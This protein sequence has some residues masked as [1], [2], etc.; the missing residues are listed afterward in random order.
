MLT[1]N[2]PPQVGEFLRRVGHDVISMEQYID[3]LRNRTFR[4]TLLVH[5]ACLS[6]RQVDG[7]RSN[8]FTSRLS[9]AG[10]KVRSHR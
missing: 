6:N 4:Q 3:F 10:D 2:F 7:K 5:Q 8:A 1:S 9:C